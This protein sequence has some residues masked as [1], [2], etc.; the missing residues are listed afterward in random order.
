M[1]KSTAVKMFQVG[2]TPEER[3][4][5]D[6]IAEHEDV[7]MSSIIRELLAERFPE[8]R[9]VHRPRSGYGGRQPDDQA[10]AT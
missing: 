10:H 4:A 1:G 5:L 9:E 6:A 3:D 2:L 7:S 8:F